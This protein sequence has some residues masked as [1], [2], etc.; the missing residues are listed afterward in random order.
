[1]ILAG[2]AG[3]RLGGVA[4]ALLLWRGRRYIDHIIERLQPQVGSIIINAPSPEP[5]RESGFATVADLWEQRQGPLA[6]ILAGLGR[7]TTPFTLI[8]PCDS[9]NVSP[10][11]ARRLSAAMDATCD[12]AYARCGEENHYLFCLLRTGLQHDLH[13]FMTEGERAVRHWFK[14]HAAVAVDFSDQPEYFVNINSPG[15]EQLLP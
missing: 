5:Y 11:L 12:I 8:V 10:Q 15:D 3:S 9:P 2:G 6:G 13:A 1:V 14:N 7:S 4:K